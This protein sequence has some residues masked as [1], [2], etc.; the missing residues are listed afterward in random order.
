MGHVVQL[1]HG[2]SLNFCAITRSQFNEDY[3][4]YRQVLSSRFDPGLC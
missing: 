2:L 1:L 3:N 4:Q